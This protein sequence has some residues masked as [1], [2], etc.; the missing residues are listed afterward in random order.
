MGYVAGVG[1][2]VPAMALMGGRFP[3]WALA[4]WG[5]A[6]ALVGIVAASLLRRKLVVEEALP[7][8][9]GN[10]TG[11]LIETIFAARAS[12]VRRAR[13]LIGGAL[14]AAAVT[15]FRDGRPA[16]DPGQ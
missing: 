4:I 13:F 5:L 6:V 11:D 2:P 12:A 1:G 3:G 14:V 10:A 15:W 7:F 9:T 16:A 8:P